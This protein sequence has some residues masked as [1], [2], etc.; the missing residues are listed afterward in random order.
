MWIDTATPEQQ[1]RYSLLVSDWLSC[2]SYLREE[3]QQGRHMDA[4]HTLVRLDEINTSLMMLRAEVEDDAEV[5]HTRPLG[6]EH[7]NPTTGAEK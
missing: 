2:M 4:R 1:F 5:K 6:V 7:Y 3:S